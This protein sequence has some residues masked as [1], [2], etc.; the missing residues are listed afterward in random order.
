MAGGA[1]GCGLAWGLRAS[2]QAMAPDALP[3][4]GEAT[5]DLRVCFQRGR[6]GR[7]W[8]PVGLFPALRRTANG[9]PRSD[10]TVVHRALARGALVTAGSDL[11]CC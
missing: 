6:D 1:A 3:R 10:R 9:V 11:R 2:F 5:I 8:N 7:V 4:I